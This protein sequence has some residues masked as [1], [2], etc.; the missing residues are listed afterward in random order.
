MPN[1][2]RGI[3]LR[4]TLTDVNARNLAATDNRTTQKL[5]KGSCEGG[6]R[7]RSIK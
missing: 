6:Q 1:A 3:A 5:H 2:G 7:N 4:P